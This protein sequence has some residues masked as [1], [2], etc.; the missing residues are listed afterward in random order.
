MLINYTK[1]IF[2]VSMKYVTIRGQPWGHFLGYL[3][4]G[5][6]KSS[7]NRATILT[8]KQSQQQKKLECEV[9]YRYLALHGKS[10]RCA[11]VFE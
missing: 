1:V 6:S 9:A 10:L 8:S 5:G 4:G 11:N 7:H 2:P 3:G